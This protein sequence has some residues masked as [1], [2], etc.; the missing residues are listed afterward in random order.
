MAISCLVGRHSVIAGGVRNGDHEFGRCEH[1]RRD[2]MRSAARA[3]WKPVPK[4]FRIV[5]RPR[6]GIAAAGDEAGQAAVGQEVTLRGVTVVGERRFG[7]QRFALVVLNARDDRH[8]GGTV[9]ALGKSGAVAAAMGRKPAPAMPGLAKTREAGPRLSDMVRR[10]DR[11]EH[12]DRA[13]TVPE[14]KALT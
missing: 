8:Y 14:R 3:G 1:C 4:G 5:W 11:P 13:A 7:S 9:D 12:L 2:L 6:T 10:G